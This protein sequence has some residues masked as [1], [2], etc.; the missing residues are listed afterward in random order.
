MRTLPLVLLA[1][2]A[3]PLAGCDAVSAMFSAALWVP[4]LFLVI[5]IWAITVAV[6]KI[7]G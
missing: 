6:L 3:L 4:G 5:L 2:V 1:L 7:R